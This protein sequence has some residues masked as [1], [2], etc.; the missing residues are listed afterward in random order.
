MG[1][2]RILL[3]TA[4][5]IFV[6]IGAFLG[7]KIIDQTLTGAA[8]QD[9]NNYSYTKAICDENSC[10]D[11]EIVC[12]GGEV[13]SMKPITDPVIFPS[14]WEDPRDPETIN[15]FCELR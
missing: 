11:Y 3:T 4:I 8:I 6:G 2:T 10:Q 5:I 7:F 12:K 9:T 1:K 14:D 13:L 15:K